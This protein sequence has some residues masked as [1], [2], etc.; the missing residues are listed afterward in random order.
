M[1]AKV[2]DFLSLSAILLL[3][4]IF[5]ALALNGLFV[6]CVVETGFS[7][8]N[9]E[10]V[11]FLRDNVARN[12]AALAAGAV[13]VWLVLKCRVTRRMN[14][15]AAIGMLCCVTAVGV[16]WV[17]A[18]KALP[19]ADA[20]FILSDAAQAASHVNALSE[21]AYLKKYPFQT[22]FLLYAECMTRLFGNSSAVVMQYCNILFVSL[23]YLALIGIARRLFQD[24]RIEL[25]TILLLLL[26]LQ[27][28]FL[29]TFVY[30]T[31]PGLAL[32]LWG[33]YAAV[34]YIQER[35]LIWML[36][37]ALLTAVAV[38]L[39]KNYALVTIACG[40]AL[41]L[42]ALRG[43]AAR[44]LL[45]CAVL[46]ICAALA[47]VLVQK[48][49]EAR[50]Q[51]SFGRGLPQSAWLAMGLGESSMCSGWHNAQLAVDFAE[52]GYDYA[53]SDAAFRHQA[54]ER[55]QLLL[56]RPRY[57][58]SF[59]YHKLTSQ[60]NTPSF[61]SIWSSAAGGHAGALPPLAES[62]YSGSGARIIERYFD[63]YTQLVYCGF[64]C[65]LILLCRK[66]RRTD[67]RLILP[68]AVLGAFLYHAVFE[69]KAQYALPYL[70]MLLPY[71]A[72]AFVT[73]RDR[74]QR[75]AG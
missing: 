11:L 41:L 74:L 31:L 44:P 34:R 71:C 17:S 68:L 6:T 65:A 45:L 61:Q 69:A 29:C 39:K 35:G 28:V 1:R 46:A 5:A 58:G 62:L 32:A 36:A 2:C 22:G 7:A 8:D 63:V 66:K 64:T 43:R 23:A 14:Q 38:V 47:P 26:C 42:N 70:P 53:R 15:I 75:R 57:L 20:K 21:S 30:G 24:E 60:W 72:Y 10:H 18:A 52:S 55:A 48:S 16:C 4:V 59:F 27:P 73:L 67:A 40:I 50:A 37:A 19:Y 9:N 51:T 54:R 56:S 25:L 12:L 49:Y 13:C 3:C 33:V